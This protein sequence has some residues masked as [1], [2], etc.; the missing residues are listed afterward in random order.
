MHHSHA[1]LHSLSLKLGAQPSS[2][3]NSTPKSFLFS[4]EITQG[5]WSHTRSCPSWYLPC[6]PPLVPSSLGLN[7]NPFPHGGSC[8]TLLS[9]LPTALSLA[10]L[11]LLHFKSSSI[12]W[13]PLL[14]YFSKSGL[15]TT[16]SSESGGMLSLKCS[17]INPCQAS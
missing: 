15:Q 14:S 4:R 1:F 9:L 10:F 16:Y 8:I 5:Y 13:L 17:S 6:L 2:K 3:I 11:S 7:Q 12:Y